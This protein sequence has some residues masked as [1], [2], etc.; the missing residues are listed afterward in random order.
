MP[1]RHKDEVI[2]GSWFVDAATWR[3]FV[4]AVRAYDARAE[5]GPRSAVKFKEEPPSIAGAEVV[6]RDDAVFVG[7]HAMTTGYLTE[8][9]LRDQWL[10]ILLDPSEGGPCIVPVSVSA[11]ARPEAARVAEHLSRLAA[12]H[13][14]KAAEEARQ[15]AEAR[16]AP[17]LSNRA[18][19]VIEGHF[20]LFMLGFFFVLL[21]AVVAG[22]YFASRWLG[23]RDKWGEP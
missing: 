20:V 13:A 3:K 10:E 21:P 19:N 12:E 8:A 14:R 15:N 9:T 11:G 23:W 2:L 22:L 7:P 5:R 17:T 18:L 1:K 6:I 4:R 16:A